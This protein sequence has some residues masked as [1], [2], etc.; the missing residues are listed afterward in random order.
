M[1]PGSVIHW[2]GFT[3]DD[4][5]VSNKYFIIL[6]D[7]RNGEHVAVIVTSQEKRGRKQVPG[8]RA[9][10]GWFFIQKGL[11]SFPKPTWVTFDRVYEFSTSELEAGVLSRDISEVDITLK[12]GVVGAIVNCLRQTSSISKHHEWLLEPAK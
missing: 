10:E 6:N 1:R 9:G 8:C 11:S 5:Y 4:G 3:F 12:Q 2:R 7:Q